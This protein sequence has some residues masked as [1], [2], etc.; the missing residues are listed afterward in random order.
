MSIQQKNTSKEPIEIPKHP[1][2][3]VFSDFGK[4]QMFGLITGAIC[5][6]TMEH[7]VNYNTFMKKYEKFFISGVGPIVEKGLFVAR[8]LAMEYGEHK[9]DIKLEKKEIKSL[10]AR[11][12][13]GLIVGSQDALKDFVGHD[14]M[15]F[16]TMI[17]GQSVYPDTPAWLISIASTIAAVGMVSVAEVGINETRYTMLKNK[18]KKTGFNSDSYYESRFLIDSEVDPRIVL[19]SVSKKFN[20]GNYETWH[21]HD[22]Y[23]DNKLKQYSARVPKLRLRLRRSE[24]TGRTLMTAQATYSRAAEIV[25]K[26]FCQHRYFPIKKDKIYYILNPETVIDGNIQEE[27]MPNN[28]SEIKQDN[29]RKLLEKYSNGNVICD[30]EYERMKT[31]NKSSIMASADFVKGNENE[32]AP[33]HVIELKTVKETDLLKEAIYYVLKKFPQV[34]QTTFDKPDIPKALSDSTP[35]IQFAHQ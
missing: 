34:Q 33:Y 8:R 2:Y 4:T 20:L 5:A 14:P 12:K 21:Y 35:Q 24:D 26:G 3:E 9:K 25:Q 16:L 10:E 27:N 29:V 19:D 32:K 13:N 15:Y 22:R 6:G 1:I 31:H 18:F 30:V 11:L 17:A 7:F 28:L 23:L